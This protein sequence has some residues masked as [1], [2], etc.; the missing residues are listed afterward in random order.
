MHKKRGLSMR[1]WR[2]A[3]MVLAYPIPRTSPTGP[4][5]KCPKCR[6]EIPFGS[7]RTL[8]SLLPFVCQHAIIDWTSRVDALQAHNSHFA[9]VPLKTREPIIS[10]AVGM[11][12]LRQRIVGRLRSRLTDEIKGRRRYW[13]SSSRHDWILDTIIDPPATTSRDW[14]TEMSDA[15]GPM[16][17]AGV[18]SFEKTKEELN[19]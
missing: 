19:T 5:W 7:H 17:Q 16:V 9:L 10:I 15:K 14:V 11:P 12:N 1:R 6:R 2:R 13:W 8:W 18:R 3:R 4:Y